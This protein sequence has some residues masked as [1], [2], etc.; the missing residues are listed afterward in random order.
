MSANMKP[1]LPGGSPPNVTHADA[2]IP[3]RV[4]HAP[5]RDGSVLVYLPDGTALVV[6]GR[7]LLR[8]PGG[9]DPDRRS[10]AEPPSRFNN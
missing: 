4:V 2:Y 3:V 1:Y 10:H 5:R 6:N 8:E 9:D 7:Q